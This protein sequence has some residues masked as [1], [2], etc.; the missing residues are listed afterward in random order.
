MRDSYI[1]KIKNSGQQVVNAPNL[2]R[3][4]NKSVV[5]NGEDLRK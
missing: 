4:S 1:G 2:K 5:R 3:D